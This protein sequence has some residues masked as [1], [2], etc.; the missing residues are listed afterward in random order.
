MC[1]V[2]VIIN[3]A[4]PWT[5]IFHACYKSET[6]LIEGW[7]YVVDSVVFKVLMNFS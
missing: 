4:I 2:C 1:V 3:Q 6:R 7:I 5:D